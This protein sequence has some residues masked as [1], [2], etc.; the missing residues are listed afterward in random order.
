MSSIVIVDD[1]RSVLA[2]FEELLS[3]RGHDVSTAIHAEQALE[4]ARTGDCDLVIMDI[5]L[6]GMNGLDALREIKRLQPR[7]PVVIMT[8]QGTME[9]AI[10]AT[11][12]GA[13]DYQ[14]KPL[15]PAEM[16][17]VI[18]KALESSRLAR[19]QVSLGSL[20]ADVAS[21]AMIGQSSNMQEVYKA[22]GRVAPTDAT[23]LIRGE[24]GTGKELVARA[25]YQH[26]LRK[27]GPFLI[28]NCAAIPETLLESELFGHEKGA[29]TG[30]TS[31][32]IGKFQQAHGGTIFL[33]EIGEIP[34]A[35][36]AKILRV[37][38]ERTVER[39]G[40]N[41][42]VRVDTRV[43][44][45]TNRA[46]EQAIREGTF[47]EDL[48][49]R[50]NVVTV[51]LPPL[52]ER[53]DDI[54]RLADFFLGRFARDLEIERPVI[55]PEAMELLMRHPWPGNVRELMHALQSVMIFTQGYPIQAADL[56]GVL[57]KPSPGELAEAG[58]RMDELLRSL[59]RQQLIGAREGPLYSEFLERVERLL[60]TEA[61]RQ[62]KGN[63]THAARLL[64]LAR[65][66]LHAKLQKL[67]L[68]A[69]K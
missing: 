52:R 29:F 41:D 43:L 45:A 47:R 11:K 12:M 60:L 24:S 69:E 23:V 65:P 13:F 28:I 38:Q 36:Q 15:E 3:A 53:R 30:A 49:H 68:S 40:G 4:R 67:G 18:D 8:G 58:R 21:D 63:Q 42:T 46:L 14:L 32:R 33:D 22:I 50:L 64:G 2:A 35:L 31:R 10:E 17:R 37:L 9:T 34:L 27:D 25:I 56:A 19:Q 5:C 54:P 16:L 61:L 66:T 51:T 62:S 1:E 57:K 59:V 7:L 55:A 6:P 48:Y 20:P 26:S 39:V 44:A